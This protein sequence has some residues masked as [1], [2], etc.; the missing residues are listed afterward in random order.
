VWRVAQ[1]AEPELMLSVR[2][3]DVLEA[4]LTGRN[5]AEIA[6]L[7]ELS[8]EVVRVAIASVITKP[9]G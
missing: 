2:E 3:R 5:T 7:L 8:P 4:A 1:S 9:P 6:D